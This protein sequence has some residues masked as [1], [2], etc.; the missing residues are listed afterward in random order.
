MVKGNWSG[1][2]C[3][4]STI[5]LPAIQEELLAKVKAVGK[6][7]IVLMSSG[8]PIDL[9]RIEKMSDAIMQIWHPGVQ[10]GNAVAGL[11]SGRYN[12]SGK[13]AMTFPYSTGQIPIYY[14]RRN[15]GRRGT[16]GIYK[17]IQSTPLY[18]FGYGLSYSKFEYDTLKV[19]ATKIAKD[20]TLTAE[21]TVRNISDRDGLETVHWYICD[22]YS[23]ITRPVKELK[24]FEKK[25]IKAGEAVQYRFE[26][27]PMR[28]LSFVDR[29]GKRYLDSGEYHI[30][31]GKQKVVIEIE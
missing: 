26:V 18:E 17:D 15:S 30:I 27:N 5:E 25:M 14:N 20:G 24:Y 10:A 6:P 1:E 9:H 2:N 31:V 21:V 13:L 11:L 29:T 4:R 16:Q 23:L 8:R 12:P 7:V 28:D 3:S 19:S 22:P